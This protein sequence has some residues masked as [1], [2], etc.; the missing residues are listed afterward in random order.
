MLKFK[1]GSFFRRLFNSYLQPSRTSPVNDYIHGRLKSFLSFQFL[2]SQYILPSHAI[3]IVSGN[4]DNVFIASKLISL[5]ASLSRPDLATR[6]FHS[7]HCKDP[8]LWNSII[9]AHFSGGNYQEAFDFFLGMRFSNT[10]PNCFTIP[11]V[12]SICAELL[13]FDDGMMIHGLV[14]KFGIFGENSAVGSSF[15][16]FY[17]K[18]GSMKDADKVFHEMHV[19][20]VVAW[21]ALII[22]YLQNGNSLKG[23]EC[24]C[25]MHNTSE[26]GGKPNNR[27]LDGGIQACGNIGALAEGKCL[28]GLAIKS[29][30]GVFNDVQSSL[31]SMYS[32]W[33]TVE[34]S[35]HLFH[36]VGYKDVMCW[37]SIIAAYARTGCV[38]ECLGFFWQMQHSGIN[39]DE[40]V[41]SCVLSSF[42]DSN[43]F[44]EGKALHGLLLR[45]NYVLN[46][47]VHRALISMYCKFGILST[48]EQIFDMLQDRI[49]ETWNLMVFEYGKGGLWKKCVNLFRDMLHLRV[50]CD[51]NS[52]VSVVSSCLQLGAIHLGK[53][54]HCYVIKSQRDYNVSVYNSLIDLYVKYGKLDVAKSIF[55]IIKK[56]VVTWNT[57]ISGYAYKG[58][59]V[60]ALA[61][62]DKMII[63]G[64]SPS[65][66]TL[67]TVLSACSRLACLEMGMKIH[68]YIRESELELNISLTTALIDMYGKCGQLE[69]ARNIFDSMVERDVITWNVMISCYGIHGDAKSAIEVF[70]HM[71]EFR[72]RPNELT[73]LAV[74]S[75]CSHTG[76]TEEG[77]FFFHKMHDYSLTPTLKHYACIVDLLGKMGNLQEA[78][79][80]VMSM[81]IAPDGGLWGAL[82]NACKIHNEVEIGLR[83]AKQA[84]T[85]DPENDGYYIT[86]SN[87][88]DSAGKWEEAEDFRQLMKKKG[89]NKRVGWSTS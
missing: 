57:M 40:I 41:I 26:D 9:K 62:F 35:C 33:G 63:E 75:A 23:L 73:F 85:A 58:E 8:F 2:D 24:L 45:R 74:L 72:V 10:P 44:R 56:D 65:S 78:E 18:C 29:G 52:L 83:I 46:Q 81:P 16:Y 14:V 50:K 34:E 1:P 31:L 71:E 37:T 61:L 20:D 70:K 15:V 88:L 43:W 27:T 64:I 59:L 54:V 4:N 82:L 49:A 87:I 38:T 69:K 32:K 28:H 3:I 19:K 55:K 17:S 51:N 5:Y 60:Q 7:V 36:E 89:V 25:V 84:I 48:A 53:S 76:L 77:K 66:A 13:S 6:V 30:Y 67:V 11:M 21:T 22:G 39:P 86:M 42:I 79:E 12:A 80:I 68:N 47:V